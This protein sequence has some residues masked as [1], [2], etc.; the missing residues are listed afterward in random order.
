MNARTDRVVC[1]S[2]YWVSARIGSSLSQQTIASNSLPTTGRFILRTIMSPRL[3]STSSSVVITIESD[4]EALSR[5]PPYVSIDLTR[6]LFPEG[7]TTISSPGWME[8]D[9][10][11][12]ANPRKLWSGRITY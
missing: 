10:T 12:P 9:T 11:R 3:M 1:I 6:V 2:Q 8:P 4:A 5:L 7:S